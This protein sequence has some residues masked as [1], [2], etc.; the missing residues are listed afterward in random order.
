MDLGLK[1]KV[2]VVT[3]A[4]RSVRIPTLRIRK[5]RRTRRSSVNGSG[6]VWAAHTVHRL[7]GIPGG[8]LP[9]H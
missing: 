2:A 8:L 1:G 9:R 6:Y 4:R 5:P 3:G 7:A